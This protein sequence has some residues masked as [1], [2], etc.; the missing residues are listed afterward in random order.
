[1]RPQDNE[2]SLAS[3]INVKRD[4]SRGFTAPLNWEILYPFF[5]LSHFKP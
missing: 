1:M 5:P 3:E 2:S 4:P